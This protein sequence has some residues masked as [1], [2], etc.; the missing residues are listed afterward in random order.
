MSLI[1]VQ[2]VWYSYGNEVMALNGVSLKIEPK[3]TIASSART[4]EGKPH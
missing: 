3:E 4:V 2:D 1:D